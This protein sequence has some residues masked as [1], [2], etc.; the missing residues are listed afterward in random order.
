MKAFWIGQFAHGNLAIWRMVGSKPLGYPFWDDHPTWA[1]LFQGFLG[2]HYSTGF[3]PHD[4]CFGGGVGR[5]VYMALC[6]PFCEEKAQTFFLGREKKATSF[7]KKIGKVK[8]ETFGAGGI[9]LIEPIGKP[10]EN[11]SRIENLPPSSCFWSTERPW[12]SALAT[13]TGR[14]PG[15]GS[16]EAGKWQKQPS[17]KKYQP[18]KE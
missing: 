11:H 17:Q 8:T 15:V 14:A 5:L 10:I 4:S 16:A 12:V 2:V 13:A 7:K 3:D 6:F 1:V 18:K 9:C